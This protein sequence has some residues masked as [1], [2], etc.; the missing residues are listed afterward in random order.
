MTGAGDRANQ[1]GWDQHWERLFAEVPGAPARVARVDRGR[2]RMLRE[3]GT[4]RWVPAP[5]DDATPVTGDWVSCALERGRPRL[6]AIADRRTA[7]VRRAPADQAQARERSARPGSGPRPQTLA[8]N[9]DLVWIT[10]SVDQPLRAGWLDRALVVAFS[11]GARAAIVVTKADLGGEDDCASTI[12]MLAPTVPLVTTS[13]RTGRGIDE[14]ATALHDGRCA[15][16]L[17]RSG[18]GK[19]SLINALVG[20][21][22]HP[23][24]AVRASD[25]KG[26]H[27]T[28]RRSL[29]LVS[30]GSVI[31]TPGVRALGLWEP[32]PGLALTFPIIAELAVGCRFA[33]CSHCHEP[34]CAVRDAV[35]R[36]GL[37]RAIYQRYLTLS[38]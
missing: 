10:H 16:L 34:G 1:L 21:T 23:T 2:V 19:S 7:L 12:S 30:G 8:A 11:S 15:A 24:A 33:D 22:A 29:T 28:T 32:A 35:E 37:E 25:A 17:G 9:M 27:T 14:L 5:T 6:V 20:A 18:S 38:Q 36:G 31:D 26:R 3:D 13:S 4:Q